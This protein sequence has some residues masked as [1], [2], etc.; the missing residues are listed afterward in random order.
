MGPVSKQDRHDPNHANADFPR[1]LDIPC[2]GDSG[3]TRPPG[4]CDSALSGRNGF[5][6]G[7]KP[8]AERANPQATDRA[9]LDNPAATRP[10]DDCVSSGHR[11]TT[12]TVPSRLAALFSGERRQSAT[13][14]GSVSRATKAEALDARR[15]LAGLSTRT[16]RAARARGSAQSQAVLD[17]NL[18]SAA[19]SSE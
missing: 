2:L 4:A 6:A 3:T 11:E 13:R 9:P 17:Q 14:G 7:Q 19:C 16:A 8:A 15:D 12:G 1:N 18:S 5:A 10:G